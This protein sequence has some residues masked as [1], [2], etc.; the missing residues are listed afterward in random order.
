M[1]VRTY[2]GGEGSENR[3]CCWKME[4]SKFFHMSTLWISFTVVAN[5]ALTAG[6]VG[7]E[8]YPDSPEGYHNVLILFTSSFNTTIT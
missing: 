6:G 5:L 8:S 7:R 4:G 3:E 2:Q 1:C